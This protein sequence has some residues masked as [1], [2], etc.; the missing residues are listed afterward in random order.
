[1]H[2]WIQIQEDHALGPEGEGDGVGQQCVGDLRVEGG[3]YVVEF[4]PRW[5]T[6]VD[7]PTCIYVS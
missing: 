5:K 3:E 7:N 4:S 2:Q 1:M 6:Y